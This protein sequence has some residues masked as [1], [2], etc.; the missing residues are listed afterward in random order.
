LFAV[1]SGSLA[2]EYASIYLKRNKEIVIAAVR[3]N[4]MAIIHACDDCTKDE[5][6][7][8]A[9][10]AQ[11]DRALLFASPM[12]K[13]NR[14][15]VFIEVTQN[16]DSL[17]FASLGLKDD[18]AIVAEAVHKQG[19]ALLHLS[20]RANND[21]SYSFVNSQSA[22]HLC[23]DELRN[24]GL[25]SYIDELLRLRKQ[26]YLFLLSTLDGTSASKR[27]HPDQKSTLTQLSKLS[28]KNLV[29]VVDFLGAP[30]GRRYKNLQNAIHSRGT[31]DI[32]IHQT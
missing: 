2:L 20:D 4:R 32:N 19:N 9:A 16:S 7:M 31:A 24:G 27:C 3:N 22:I 17:Q 12:L 8:K 5:D 10:V 11:S 6:I 1:L 15:V 18:F 21:C 28:E 29:M 13:E 14:E 26:F 25:R 30:H 23:S